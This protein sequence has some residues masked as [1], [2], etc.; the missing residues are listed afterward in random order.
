MIR[1][2]E[3][4]R[5]SRSHLE[6][7]QSRELSRRQAT[8]SA[9]VALQTLCTG[10]SAALRP[11]RGSEVPAVSGA[12]GRTM[13]EASCMSASTLPSGWNEPRTETKPQELA[14]SALGAG[15]CRRVRAGVS[16]GANSYLRPLRKG[17]DLLFVRQ[18]LGLLDAMSLFELKTHKLQLNHLLLMHNVFELFRESRGLFVRPSRTN[19]P[20]Q[21]LH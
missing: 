14:P 1:E 3:R 20:E 8:V 5:F 9:T 11:Q 12:S 17:A 10:A 4:E 15:V 19:E 6:E 13:A 18:T 7:Q 16:M 2:R 21:I